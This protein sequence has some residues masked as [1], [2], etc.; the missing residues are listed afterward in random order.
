MKA[1]SGSGTIRRKEVVKNGKVYVFFEARYS[2]H[3]KQKSITGKTQKE[4][5]EKLR[6]ITSEIDT[7]SYIEPCKTTLSSWLDIWLSDYCRNIKPGT[8]N[9]YKATVENHIKKAAIAKKR[10]DALTPADLQHFCNNLS[11]VGGTEPL[12][13]KTV[14]NTCGV[15]HKALSKAVELNLIYRNPADLVELP[16]LVKPEV[17]PLDD[18]LTKLFLNAIKGDKFEDVFKLDL[19]TGLRS[20]ELLG[21]GW[22]CINF[23]TG[24]IVI[25]QQLQLVRGS[26]GVYTIAP[27]KNSK[28]RT[29]YPGAYVLDILKNRKAL[30]TA[31][32]KEALKSGEP[33]NNQFNLCFTDEHGEHLRQQTVCNHLKKA[34][35]EIGFPEGHLHSLRHSYAT[36]SLQNGDSV[37]VVQESLGHATASF[38]LQVYAHATEEALKNSGERM[39]KYFEEISAKIG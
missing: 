15:L 22:D 11:R 21:L 18:E 5:A 34:M 25:K 36:R 30:Q 1:A 10:L 19:L 38:T 39:Q 12:S 32:R 24:A 7:G 13:T 29:I 27:T 31:Q 2:Y 17:K 4:V 26:H 9:T 23:D 35:A 14:L 8:L 33:W 16:K 3:G 37:K 20:G 28:S 6:K